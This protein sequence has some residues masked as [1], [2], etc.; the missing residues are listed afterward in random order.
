MFKTSLKTFSAL[1]AL[2]ITFAT[3]VQAQE[4]MP[5]SLDQARQHALEHNKNLANAGLAVDEAGLML[6]E[7]IAQGLPQVNATIDYQN[8]FGSTASFGDFPG[9]E[10]E[11]S[12]TSNLGVS[13]GQ[14]I[15]SGSYIVGIQTAR[16]YR[17]M[18]KTSLEKSALEIKAQVSQAYY[19]ALISMESQQIVEAN[20]ENMREMLTRT[21]TMVD[22]GVAEEVDF[23]QLSVQVAMLEDAQRAAGRQVELAMNMLRLHM[24]LTADTQIEL[25]DNLEKIIETTNYRESLTEPFAL[26]ESPDFR[27][28]QLQTD[29]AEKQVNMQRA[30]Y[31]P[32]ITGFYSFTEK[33]LKPELDLTPSHVVGLNMEIPIFSSGARRARVSQARVNQEIAL[34]QRE[35]LVQQLS[36]QEKQLRFNLSNAIEQYESQLSNLEV[37]RRVINSINNKFEQGLVSSLDLT[38]ANS[39]Y[40]QAENSYISA[41][42]QLMDAQL[43]LEKLLNTL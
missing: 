12:P 13:V 2:V 36:I 3:G 20:L 1:C 8:F 35:L 23:D 6:R 28:M 17:E 43:E 21:R 40:L 32:S 4:S 19:L 24:G 29:M 31:L 5:L 30:A 33:L 16:L 10:I 22:V 9:M 42:M 14:L 18:S 15:F 7:T 27:L 41:L 11:F 38:T 39:N 34:N 37:A 25:T 26:N